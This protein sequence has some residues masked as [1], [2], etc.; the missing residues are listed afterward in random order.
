MRAVLLIAL[1]AC[2]RG[3]EAALRAKLGIPDGAQRVM[4]FA[5]TAHLDVDWQKT[6][7]DYYASYVESILL[8]SRALLERQP[9][10]AYGVAEMAYLERHLAQHP[11]EAA[12]LRALAARGALRVVGGGRTSPDTLLPETELLV[13]DFLFGAQFADD[14]LGVRATAAWLPDSFGHAA[15][16]PDLLAAAGYESVFLGRIDGAPTLYES[17]S[18]HDALK[19]G[20]TAALLA[21]LGSA[22]FF[23]RGPGGGRILAHWQPSGIYCTGDDIDYDEPLQVPGGHIGPFRG[24]DAGFTDRK[25]DAYLK[26]LAPF[27]KTPY[28]FVPVGCDFQHPKEK[29]LAYLD[30][31]DQRHKDAYAVAAT[32]EDYAKLVLAH[33]EELPEVQ[34]D[35]TPYFTGF[36]G[37]RPGIKRAVRDA[38]RGFLSAEPFAAA[39][40]DEGRDILAKAAPAL[41]ELTLSNHHDFVTGTSNDAVVAAEQAPL[42]ADA[43]AA[44]DAALGDV[45]RAIAARI[46]GDGPRLLALN[47][48]SVPQTAALPGTLIPD[49][50]PFGWR[51]VAPGAPLT[52]EVAVTLDGGRAVLMNGRVRAELTTEALTSLQIDGVEALSGPSLLVRA[53]SD[54]GGLWRLGH[55]MPGCAL[56][57]VELAQ[58]GTLQVLQDDGLVARV[59]LRSGDVV[60]EVSLQAQSAALDVAVE[61]AALPATTRT[62]SFALA[63][64]G[65][66]LTS[67]AG[68]F[69]ERKGDTLYQPTFWPAVAWTLSGGWAILQRQSTGAR[70]DASGTVELLAVRDA[71]SEQCDVEGPTD[72][73]S[74]TAVHR[75]EWRIARADSASAAE[76][77]AQAFDRPVRVFDVT[78]VSGA[79]L[80]AEASLASIAGDA[81]ISAI[82]PADR[83]A[84]VIVRAL[85]LPGPGVV[86]LSPLLGAPSMLTDTSERD[87]RSFGGVRLRR[88]DVGALPTLRLTR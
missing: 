68:G 87:L 14:A 5:Q 63:G 60:R 53:Y 66:F 37:S 54:Q 70:R 2:S 22:D 27:A 16:V 24:D 74:D 39:L 35:L 72:A 64:A 28:V 26:A 19:A 73:N 88:E 15:T 23:W 41:R 18:G 48:A 42:L 21:S 38:A 62:V 57:P 1:F 44:G 34:A 11:E 55:E 76:R 7:P 8:E 33:A 9:R 56:T 67:L 65:P 82:K 84:G 25:I 3:P 86:Q 6:F 51:L 69:A 31:Y 61:T 47:P 43:Q 78:G 52:R 71:R 20:S 40:G 80:P 30:G 85:L 4:I 83:G 12:P 46:P 81:L 49:V 13:R 75:L 59:A 32:F 29:L 45:A 10:A 50:P 79:G 36:L 77:A 58:Q 17:L